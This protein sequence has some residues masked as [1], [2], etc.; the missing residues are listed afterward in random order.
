MA[1]S[2]QYTGGAAT[3]EDFLDGAG[4]DGALTVGREPCFRHWELCVHSQGRTQRPPEDFLSALDYTWTWPEGSGVVSEV[5]FAFHKENSFCPRCPFLPGACTVGTV[6]NPSHSL[7]CGLTAD[8]LCWLPG[9]LLHG[10]AYLS[11]PPL[12]LLH[13]PPSLHTAL[14]PGAK[15]SLEK[16]S[17]NVHPHH[18]KQSPNSHDC[19]PFLAPIP[20]APGPLH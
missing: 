9:Y 16:N 1:N 8:L 13:S 4:L 10:R 11:S 17:I 12:P 5:E 6:A 18:C 2:I 3:K 15:Q 7:G 14:C 20:A 19:W